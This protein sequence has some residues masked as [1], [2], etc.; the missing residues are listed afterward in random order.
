MK[1]RIPKAIYSKELRE[2]AEVKMERYLLKSGSVLCEGNS[3][4]YAMIKSLHED[5]P[6]PVMCRIYE[7]SI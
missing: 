3:V 2:Q 4:K 6:M 1:Q 5:Y 7:V